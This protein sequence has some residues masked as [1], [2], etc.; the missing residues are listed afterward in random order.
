MEF[1]F[2]HKASKNALTTLSEHYLDFVSVVLF[3][4][5]NKKALS[6]EIMVDYDLH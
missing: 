1:A 4:I 5:E 2:K 6:E 3:C